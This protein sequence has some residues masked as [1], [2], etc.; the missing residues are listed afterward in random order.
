MKHKLL[1]V[2]SITAVV[3]FCLWWRATVIGAHALTG[4][5]DAN[6]YYTYARNLS[7]GFGPVF[8]PGS[9]R[10]EGFTSPAWLLLL[11]LGYML[12]NGNIDAVA[13]TL[14]LICLVSTL[15]IVFLAAERHTN[16]WTA[17]LVILASISTGG[18]IDWLLLSGMDTGLWTLEITTAAVLMARKSAPGTL[19]TVVLCAIAVTRP[20]GMMIAPLLAATDIFIRKRSISYLIP[21]VAT[22]IGVIFTRMMVF[23]YPFPNTFYAKVS[24]SFLTN[25]RDGFIYIV[26]W[27]GLTSLPTA[28]AFAFVIYTIVRRRLSAGMDIVMSSAGISML[29]VA[30]VVIEGGDHFELSRFLQPVTA[31]VWLAFAIMLFEKQSTSAQRRAVGYALIIAVAINQFMPLSMIKSIIIGRQVF[32][33]TTLSKITYEFDLAAEGRMQGTLLKSQFSADEL[34]NL[35]SFTVGGISYAYPGEVTDLLG[36]NNTRIAHAKS[37]G[38]VGKRNHRGFKKTEFY[39][40]PPEVLYCFTARSDSD[41]IHYIADL[42]FDSPDFNTMTH[43]LLREERFQAMFSL[44]RVQQKQ[45]ST[46]VWLFARNDWAEQIHDSTTLTPIWSL[47]DVNA[48]GVNL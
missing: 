12:T 35:G 8:S 31:L 40:Y 18:F 36:L 17:Y 43:G 32:F 2:L 42:V 48:K 30:A 5:D 41:A 15:S 37:E 3:L 21:V 33:H 4:I 44:Y 26:K 28:I 27:T 38:E 14:S 19:F 7:D 22:I 9:S 45:A 29:V 39:A 46:H 25:I 23:G 24:P 6:I 13:L 34:P 20:E 10:V 11:T 1:V 47:L 16:T